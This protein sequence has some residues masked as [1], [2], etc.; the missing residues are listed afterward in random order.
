[1]N[2]AVEVLKKIVDFKKKSVSAAETSKKA[3][4]NRLH[5]VCKM[6]GAHS[7]N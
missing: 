1:M 3:F 5:L 4:E 2:R 6:P 7:M